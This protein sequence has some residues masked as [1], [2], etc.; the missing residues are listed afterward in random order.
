MIIPQGATNNCS[1]WVCH[2]PNCAWILGFLAATS[3]LAVTGTGWP[4]FEGSNVC[5]SSSSTI[6]FM[7]V[8]SF[9]TE[10][11]G[12]ARCARSY[13]SLSWNRAWARALWTTSIALCSWTA[14]HHFPT[15]TGLVQPM[16][17]HMLFRFRWS[18]QNLFHMYKSNF[19]H[20]EWLLTVKHWP[21]SV[22]L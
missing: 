4:L 12:W 6:S 19:D 8:T 7:L 14:Q 20:Y 9:P 11:S 16:I 1:L 21:M 2:W 13:R 3:E 18:G 15:M 22:V 17:A 5:S 10:S